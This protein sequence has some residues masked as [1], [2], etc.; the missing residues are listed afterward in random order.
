[1]KIIV[2]AILI[3]ASSP[4]YACNPWAA[5][6]SKEQQECLDSNYRETVREREQEAQTRALQDIA[7][8]LRANNILHA[9]E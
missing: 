5:G 8:Q 2:V 7:D 6:G 3:A 4:A 1:M 9:G